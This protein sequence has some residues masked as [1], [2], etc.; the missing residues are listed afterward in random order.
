MLFKIPVILCD[1]DDLSN[2]FSTI[3]GYYIFVWLKDELNLVTDTI[4]WLDRV[5]T[6]ELTHLL[7]FY[8]FN[9]LPYT[10]YDYLSFIFYP[11][12]FSEGTAQILSEEWDPGRDLLLRLA[13]L[14]KKVIPF[15]RITGFYEMNPLEAR[16]LYE[17]G[18]SLVRYLA[19]KKGIYKIRD[20]NTGVKF[21][22]IFLLNPFNFD[23][24]FFLSTS[25]FEGNFFKEWY[26]ETYNWYKK[27]YKGK[28]KLK[29]FKKIE[30]PF[31]ITLSY[32]KKNDI[33]IFVGT[34]DP[35]NLY[36]ELALKIRSK[37]KIIDRG[38]IG[39]K[40]SLSPSLSKIAYT[41]MIR[42]KNGAII[43]EIFVYDIDKGKKF[44]IKNSERAMG[45]IWFLDEEHIL[46][47]AYDKKGSDIYISNMKGFKDKIVDL[48]MNE[49]A[50]D[51]FVI[52][53]IIYFLKI[54]GN[55]RI[56]CKLENYEIKK[57]YQFDY[58]V[59]DF[60][61]DEKGNIY[62]IS[63]PEGFFTLSKINTQNKRI[64]HLI[65]FIEGISNLYVYN[66]K[67]F[68][69]GTYDLENFD[70]YYVIDTLRETQINEL[71]NVYFHE[72]TY[73]IERINRF[74]DYKIKPYKSLSSLRPAGIFICPL[75]VYNL[76]YL[77]FADPLMKDIFLSVGEVF[78]PEK[79]I[80]YILS[81]LYQ[82]S[83]FYPNF[84]IGTHLVKTDTTRYYFFE[85][86]IHFP[87]SFSDLYKSSFIYLKSDFYSDKEIISSL[88]FYLLKE[89]PEV[90]SPVNRTN[91]FDLYLAHEFSARDY[92]RH[93]LS[94][95]FLSLRKKLLNFRKITFEIW[96]KMSYG[97]RKFKELF[98][99]RGMSFEERKGYLYVSGGMELRFQIFK[100]M[101]LRLGPFYFGRLIGKFFVD[102]IKVT[103]E[104]YTYGSGISNR[105]FIGS[106][107]PL[108][109]ET[110]IYFKD[111]KG[112]FYVLFNAPFS[113]TYLDKDH[114][115]IIPK[116]KR[117][118][119]LNRV[120]R[121]NPI[122][123]P[124]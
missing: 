66:N 84:I 6:H 29:K 2:G 16:L 40:I 34:D 107:L 69:S 92:K 121:P 118:Y 122:P 86:G 124:M 26:K 4:E 62:F 39:T 9:F 97:K 75:I 111:K 22:N 45:R 60:Y 65:E 35:E 99:I 109:I 88:S 115:K 24:S 14:N 100:E 10:I 102:Y 72:K 32:I 43:G 33:E 19:F 47:S 42:N 38:N 15:R 112:S 8:S 54:E 98:T 79:D 67:I 28:E 94:N 25:S 13:F 63:C 27:N 7:S 87:F 41:K 56:L 91:G 104:V 61:P 68:F 77:T 49:Y 81:F 44:E 5:L 76:F 117:F 36:L 53:S 105:I 52:D 110:G 59:R 101:K 119:F 95:V 20:I 113:S 123:G 21:L 58:Y 78:I 74:N 12:Y 116:F 70:I 30:S 114:T 46:Y 120:T 55:K 106:Y 73:R 85:T 82:N 83:H 71:K 23:L 50:I 48:S 103:E 31:K 80:F 64:S 37:I 108:I 11:A 3:A 1:V 57:I 18:H 51:L 93:N 17:E 96:S 90:S 89:F